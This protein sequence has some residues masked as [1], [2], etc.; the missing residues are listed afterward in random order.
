MM[1]RFL[2]WWR[3]PAA[4]DCV[5]SNGQFLVWV[6]GPVLAFMGMLWWRLKRAYSLG[7]AVLPPS[8]PLGPIPQSNQEKLLHAPRAGLSS[9]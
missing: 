8:Y 1:P 2:R 7:Q 5:C 4:P 6:Y 3:A 9:S